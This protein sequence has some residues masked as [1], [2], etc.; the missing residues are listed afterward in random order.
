MLPRRTDQDG[1]RFRDLAD[2]IVRL[3]HFFDAGHERRIVAEVPFL[4][5]RFGSH[6]V[7]VATGSPRSPAARR[8]RGLTTAPTLAEQPP[9][10]A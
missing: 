10:P 4:A 9:W 5:R 8:A 7:R 6:G 3:H 2:V 1:T